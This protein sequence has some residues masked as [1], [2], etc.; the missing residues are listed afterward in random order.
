MELN[1]I[2]HYAIAIYTGCFHLVD[3]EMLLISHIIL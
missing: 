1:C 2:V 3:I